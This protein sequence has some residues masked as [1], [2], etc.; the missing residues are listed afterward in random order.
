MLP[1]FKKNNQAMSSGIIMKTRPADEKPEIEGEDED[2]SAAI[3]S[4][5]QEL[6][7][8]VHARDVKAVAAA[9]EDA[10][11]ILEDMPHEEESSESVEPHS[12]DAQNI[13]AG[14]E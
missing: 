7:R 4:C 12:Y 1:F 3:E 11:E 2:S 9:I 14:K 5:A 8:A 6:I 13:K 10:F